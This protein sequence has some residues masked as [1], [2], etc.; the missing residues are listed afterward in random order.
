[1]I[2]YN[3]CANALDFKMMAVSKSK[4][5]VR[6]GQTGAH[7]SRQITR[8]LLTKSLEQSHISESGHCHS[9]FRGLYCKG[10]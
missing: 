8:F 10:N 7:K 4:S 3:I 9:Y 1:M 6:E 5:T 2:L